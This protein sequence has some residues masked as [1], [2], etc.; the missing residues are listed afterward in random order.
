M[1]GKSYDDRLR[2]LVLWTLEE[3]RNRHEKLELFKIFK[4]LS[5]FKMDIDK[6]FM[7][8]ENT[9]HTKGLRKTQCTRDITRH[10]FRIRYRSQSS[11]LLPNQINPVIIIDGTC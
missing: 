7:L 8:N 6:L 4:E 9:K 10:F 5:R 3:R 11:F 1:E 2:Y